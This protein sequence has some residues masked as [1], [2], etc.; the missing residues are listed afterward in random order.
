MA[1]AL[2]DRQDALPERP[3]RLTQPARQRAY[4]FIDSITVHTRSVSAYMNAN[5]P[6]NFDDWLSP[7]STCAAGTFSRGTSRD[8]FNSVD[9]A[10]LMASGGFVGAAAPGGS[11]HSNHGPAMR[12]TQQ[13]SWPGAVSSFSL[14]SHISWRAAVLTR[15]N[16][17]KIFRWRRTPQR[18]IV[19]GCSGMYTKQSVQGSI[20]RKIGDL[21]KQTF[22]HD[23]ASCVARSLVGEQIASR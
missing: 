20:S 12:L 8:Y 16:T 19:T 15:C 10:E 7:V 14:C 2:A 9:M 11:E 3:S 23:S 1:D 22:R 4:R 21:R 17:L 6:P 13:H 18:E 5:H